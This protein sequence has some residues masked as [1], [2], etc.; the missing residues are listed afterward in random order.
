MALLRVLAVV[1]ES[2]KYISP[3]TKQ[4]EKTIPWKNIEKVIRKF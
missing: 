4:S 3:I 2:T 1:G